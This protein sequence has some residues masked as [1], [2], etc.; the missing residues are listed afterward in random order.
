MHQYVQRFHQPDRDA[1]TKALSVSAVDIGVERCSLSGSHNISIVGVEIGKEF[2]ID[3]SHLG[4]IFSAF[5]IGYA[6]FQIPGGMLARYLGP[7]RM[8]GSSV[9]LWAHR[10]VWGCSSVLKL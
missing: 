8:L 4:W 6:A 7:R 10:P 3:N 1:A 5:L 2:G 9:V